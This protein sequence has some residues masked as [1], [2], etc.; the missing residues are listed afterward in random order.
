[1]PD[2]LRLP[3]RLAP[4]LVPRVWGGGRLPALHGVAWE[5]PAGSD[6]VGESWLADGASVVA[7][8]PFEGATVA[9]LAERYGRDLLGEASTARYGRRLALLVKL[10]DAA[11]DLSVQV[12]PDDEYALTHEAGTGHLG[13]A[14]AWYVL[15]AAPGAAV[16]RGFARDVTAAE[17]RAAALDGTLPD[18]LRRVPVGPGDVVVNPP[19]TVHAVGAGLLLYEVQQSS[20]ITYRLFDYGRVDAAGRRRELHLDKALEVADLAASPATLEPA[21]AR[22]PGAWRRL[23]T[24]P[25]F[26]LDAALLAPGAGVAGETTAASCEVLTVVE[27]AAELSAGGEALA[28]GTGDTVLLPAALGR[29]AL[30]GEG[31]VLRAAVA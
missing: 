31:E 8:S 29:Y 25:E 24:R 17:V 16:L 11:D 15:R 6:P 5:A 21:P 9:E 22:V 18:L 2:A 14:E 3:L 7:G 13:K 1:M 19:G 4:R 26:V 12:H 23:V 10:L 28:L 20:D 27:G 30:A